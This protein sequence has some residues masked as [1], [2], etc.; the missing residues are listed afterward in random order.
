MINSV[1]FEKKLILAAIRSLDAP[2]SKILSHD[3]LSFIKH[4]SIY[5]AVISFL[6]SILLVWLRNAGLS[7]WHAIPNNYFSA[8]YAAFTFILFYEII[9]MVFAL[10]YS[11]ARSVAKQYE[12]I[13]LVIVRHIFEYTGDFTHIKSLTEDYMPFLSLAAS[14]F[15]SLGIFFL[16]GIFRKVQLH[17]GL[18]TTKENLLIFVFLKKILALFLFGV[19]LWLGVQ[20]VMHF[21]SFLISDPSLPQGSGDHGHFGYSFYKIVFSVMIFTDILL[22]LITMQYGGS[23]QLVFRNTGLLIST[24]LL[25]ISFSAEMITGILLVNTAVI[26]AILSTLIYNMHCKTAAAYREKESRLYELTGLSGPT[27]SVHREESLPV[28]KTSVRKKT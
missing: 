22:V 10:P 26:I 6:T 17:T 8:I 20:E 2:L 25:R 11:I 3:V 9:S 21:I 14:I 15:G 7:E 5:A 27:V 13:S 4:L 19:I 18:E 1:H 24:V 16:I 28:K 23:Y 12:V